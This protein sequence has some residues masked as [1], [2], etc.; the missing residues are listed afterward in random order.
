MEEFIHRHRVESHGPEV[1]H[2]V[3][4][5]SRVEGHAHRVL[6]PCV[7]NENPQRRKAHAYG[8]E[9]GGCQVET[10]ADFVPAEEHHG[11]ESG[12]HEKRHYAFDGQRCSED[13]AYEPAVVAP[14]CAEL[15]F[16][17]YASGH[18]TSEID[19]EKSHPEFGN[20]A[21]AGVAGAHVDALHDCHNQR[22]A[23][24]EGYE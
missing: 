21:P 19:A 3:S 17:D 23:D 13:V 22:Q 4:H 12:F 1:S 16:E 24:C 8:G 6:H 14:V 20:V 10:A 2:D 5:L 7:G 9:P 15:E 11:N 18:A